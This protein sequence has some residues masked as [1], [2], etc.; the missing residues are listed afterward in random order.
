MH[1]G[2]TIPKFE[3]NFFIEERDPH[4]NIKNIKQVSAD[5][6]RIQIK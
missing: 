5:K 4:L 3:R 2:K 1:S 6:E